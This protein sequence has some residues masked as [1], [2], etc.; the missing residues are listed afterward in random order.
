MQR[1]AE[2]RPIGG[3]AMPSWP[4]PP[5][6]SGPEGRTIRYR[7]ELTHTDVKTLPQID[8]NGQSKGRGTRREFPPV[9]NEDATRYAITLA[10]IVLFWLGHES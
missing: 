10:A 5:E 7:R 6:G 2:R 1:L 3:G 4:S 8:G 9:A